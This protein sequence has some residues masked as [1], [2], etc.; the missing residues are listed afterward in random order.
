MDHNSKW[1]LKNMDKSFTAKLFFCHAHLRYVILGN[2][3]KMAHYIR[4]C[5][6]IKS[7]ILKILDMTCVDRV[8]KVKLS[9]SKKII[10]DE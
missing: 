7:N 5:A 9:A 1:R 3:Q 6:T 4:P 2:G 10:L 8:L